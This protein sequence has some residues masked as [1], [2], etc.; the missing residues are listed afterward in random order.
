LEEYAVRNAVTKVTIPYGEF[1]S[2]LSKA[3]AN[4]LARNAAIAQL[5][6]YFENDNIIVSCLDEDRPDR[7]VEW[8]LID[9]EDLEPVQTYTD[10]EWLDY[11][12]EHDILDYN[13][14]R[15]VG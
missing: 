2:Y 11:Q 3:D 15:P 9:V 1:K 5:N 4:I 10:G 7:P 8:D 12:I 6:C 14:P 13:V